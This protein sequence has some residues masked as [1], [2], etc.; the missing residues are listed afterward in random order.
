MKEL[1]EALLIMFPFILLVIASLHELQK[2]R[3]RNK[4]E[5]KN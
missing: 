5:R 3:R 1:G 4:S 2:T